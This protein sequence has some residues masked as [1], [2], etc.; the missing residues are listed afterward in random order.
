M[1]NEMTSV[2]FIIPTYRRPEVLAKCLACLGSMKPV[3]GVSAE[4]RIYDNGFPHDS[5]HVADAFQRSLPV[6]YRV[7]EQGHGLGYSLCLGASEAQ[8]DII[9]ELNDD[10]LVGA[11]FLRN[12]MATFQS[13]SSIGVVGVRAIEKGYESTGDSIGAID[14]STL[15]VRGN[16]DRPTEDVLDVEHVYGFCY[17]YRR[18][19]L[20]HGAVHD[21]VLLAKDYSSGN[22]IETDQCLSA[23]K[24]GGAASRETASGLRRD[25]S[26]VEIKPL[27]KHALPFSETLR[28]VWKKLDCN[29]LR[30]Q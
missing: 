30:L 16:F 12:I 25:F 26:E 17:A 7:N 28:A 13:D 11:D 23:R 29:S 15:E 2:S 10:A 6:T 27:E 9:V 3:D 19:M 1:S 24:R 4:I 8:G 18:E 14:S 20:D 5:R 22:R 21:R